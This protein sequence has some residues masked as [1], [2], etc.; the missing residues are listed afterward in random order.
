MN[1]SNQETLEELNHNI[2]MAPIANLCGGL[3][4]SGLPGI[5]L[6]IAGMNP[7]NAKIQTRE[8]I[9]RVR[10]NPILH[11]ESTFGAAVVVHMTKS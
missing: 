2:E 11:M 9:V 3:S 8:D 6:I 1:F 4:D 7:E 5:G 10:E